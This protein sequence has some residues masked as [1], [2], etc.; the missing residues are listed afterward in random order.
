[1]KFERRRHPRHPVR[2]E[3]HVRFEDGADLRAAFTRNISKGGIF[4]EMDEPLPEGTELEVYLEVD[5]GTTLRLIGGVVRTV[6]DPNAEVRGCGVRFIDVD[7]R[8]K[9]KLHVFMAK[10]ARVSRS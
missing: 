7:K 10:N 3:V 8:T 5:G 1:M 2:H 6:D 9:M 4:I